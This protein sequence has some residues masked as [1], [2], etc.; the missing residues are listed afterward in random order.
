MDIKNILGLHPVE[1]INLWARR[2]F[3]GVAHI[4][5]GIVG[6]V[7]FGL[8]YPGLPLW[9]SMQLARYRQLLRE[10]RMYD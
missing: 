6:L 4:I 1:I 9:T 2:L 5:T 7:T 3:M 8:W 10:R